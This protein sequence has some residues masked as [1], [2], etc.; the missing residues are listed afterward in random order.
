MLTYNGVGVDRSPGIR[1]PKGK[2]GILRFPRDDCRKQ[3]SGLQGWRNKGES[4]GCSQ[5]WKA[6]LWGGHTNCPELG[7]SEEGQ[8]DWFWVWETWKPEL[9]ALLTSTAIAKV[10]W[11]DAIRRKH[12]SSLLLLFPPSTPYWQSLI[13]TQ[14]AK[15]RGV[16]RVPE[17]ASQ[18]RV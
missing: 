7:V 5:R 14:L 8:W 3:L 15:E 12:I 6:D 10:S 13:L 2:W 4:V 1:E 11:G 16:C 18:S 17:P 9:L